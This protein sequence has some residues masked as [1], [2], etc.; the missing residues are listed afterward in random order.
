[1]YL[2]E[3]CLLL[4]RCATSNVTLESKRS[5][6]SS[7]AGKKSAAEKEKAKKG[8]TKNKMKNSSGSGNKDTA[9]KSF[10]FE[11]YFDFQCPIRSVKPHQV[12]VCVFACVCVRACVCFYACV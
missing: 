11:Q 2:T 1:M 8:E 9:D 12:C 3:Q 4:I 5:K 7:A 10:K 6:T